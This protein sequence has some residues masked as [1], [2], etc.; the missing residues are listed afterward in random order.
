MTDVADIQRGRDLALYFHNESIGR[1]G[2]TIKTIDELASRINPKRP[3]L[4]FD[5]LGFQAKTLMWNGTYDLE[6]CNDAMEALARQ[7]NGKIPTAG[8]FSNAISKVTQSG[9][10]FLDSISYT[11]TQTVADVAKGAQV[12]GQAV[13]DTGASL[14]KIAPLLVT[15]G[16]IAYVYLFI[17]KRS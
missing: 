17:K 11:T 1:P 6:D 2:Y 15:V 10:S 14:T 16:V 5:G 12:V 8:S 4:F 7:S 3:D 13:I 9:P